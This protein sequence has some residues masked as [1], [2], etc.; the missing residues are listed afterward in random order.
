MMNTSKPSTKPV[1]IRVI[2]PVM[3][4]G[5]RREVGEVLTVSG[6]E[7]AEMIAGPRCQLV[8]DEDLPAV[9]AAVVADVALRR[10]HAVAWQPVDALRDA[11]AVRFSARQRRGAAGVTRLRPGLLHPVHAAP[12]TE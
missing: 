7:A 8:H 3:Y 1:K 6:T 10:A 5:H 12:S 4:L 11:A 2:K 9:R